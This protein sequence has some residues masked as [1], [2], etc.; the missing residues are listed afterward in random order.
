[1]KPKLLRRLRFKPAEIA[2]FVAP[3]FVLLLAFATTWLRPRFGRFVRPSNYSIDAIA[4]SPDGQTIATGD[5]AGTIQFWNARTGARRAMI[6]AGGPW[7]VAV[8]FSRDGRYFAATSGN[9]LLLCNGRTGA[10]LRCFTGPYKYLG[11]VA[12]SPDGKHVAAGADSGSLYQG[13]G[14]VCLWDTPMGGQTQQ[15]NF[16]ISQVAA[17]DFAPDGQSFVS[18]S[19]ANRGSASKF[20]AVQVLHCWDLRT[21]KLRWEKRAGESFG[22]VKFTPDSS[23]IAIGEQIP[24]LL[25]ARTGQ[26]VATMKVPEGGGTWYLALCGGGNLLAGSSFSHSQDLTFWDLTTGDVVPRTLKPDGSPL[27]ELGA[28]ADAFAFSRDEKKL[29]YVD[30]A[31]HLQMWDTSAIHWKKV[32]DQ[33]DELRR[34][35]KLWT[36]DMASEKK[37]EETRS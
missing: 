5:N 9:S 10:L 37:L 14:A 8:A 23:R 15:F 24:T 35:K 22:A 30:G 19:G 21:K 34:A 20:V 12:F 31:N 29:A 33:P 17:L 1:V 36:L 27:L 13:R 26:T 2:L 32:T 6:Q 28:G 11:A 3:L 7:C 4:F 25:D 16:Q 18:F